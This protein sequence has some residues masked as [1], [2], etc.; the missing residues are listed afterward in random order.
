M[1]QIVALTATLIR[2]PFG[3]LG[4][5]YT[6]VNVQIAVSAAL[7]TSSYEIVA[8]GIYPTIVLLIV[9]K[10]QTLNE[11]LLFTTVQ[12]SIRHNREHDVR[13]LTQLRFASPVNLVSTVQ[14]SVVLSLDR[15]ISA[16]EENLGERNK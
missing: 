2:L 13:S 12:P 10:Y 7:T 6:P 15:S 9:A 11:T 14:A 3:T 8:Q 5:I 4:D 1:T 16:E